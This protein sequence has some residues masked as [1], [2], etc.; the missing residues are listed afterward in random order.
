MLEQE[1]GDVGS[2]IKFCAEVLYPEIAMQNELNND[3]YMLSSSD[4]SSSS[5]SSEELSDLYA[6]VSR[7][8]LA[9]KQ[10]SRAELARSRRA[11]DFANYCRTL[12][13]LNEEEFKKEVDDVKMVS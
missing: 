9:L 5:S 10:S 11:G 12:S 13:A 4:D 2:I 7:R 6:S 3:R 1:Q 8:S